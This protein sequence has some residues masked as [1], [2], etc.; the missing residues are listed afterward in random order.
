[1]FAFQYPWLLVLLAVL[2]LMWWYKGRRISISE[3]LHLATVSS[4]KATLTWRIRLHI[5]AKWLLYGAAA[6]TIFAL[7]RPQKV[8]FQKN[9]EGQGIDILLALDIS[10]SMLARD[11]K[12]DRLA[13]AKRVAMDFV[14]SRP[15]DRIGLVSFAGEA[16]V[17]Y[18]LT[19]D[20][21][22]IQ[23]RIDAM[24]VGQLADGTAIGMGLGTALTRL[25]DTTTRSRIVILMTDGENNAGYYSPE[26][27]TDIATELGVK[28]YTIGIGTDQL[29]EAPI[30]RNFDGSY[31]FAARRLMIDERLLKEIAEKTGGQYFLA[32]SEDMLRRI[33]KQIDQLERSNYQIKEVVNR[34]EFFSYFLFPALLLLILY[35]LIRWLW[36]KSLHG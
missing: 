28:V 8:D 35:A 4:L 21:A 18:P 15:V 22:L 24:T 20:H 34:Q 23:S 30:A 6:L 33:Y 27:A 13:V 10:P 1:M 32:N 16:I 26:Q 12:P 5:H 9:V 17:E 25:A 19:T 14:R 3:K 36:A 29:A 11:F 7:A 31:E 2:P